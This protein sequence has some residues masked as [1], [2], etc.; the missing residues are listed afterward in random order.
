MLFSCPFSRETKFGEECKRIISLRGEQCLRLTNRSVC[1]ILLTILSHHPIVILASVSTV[2][3]VI[4]RE[5]FY[6]WSGTLCAVK[7]LYNT[8][9]SHC[10]PL[11]LRL[12][13]TTVS[14]E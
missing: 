2:V 14:L 7:I 13:P 8:K 6:I 1:F 5:P 9:A 4:S 12:T 11:P 3:V 10:A